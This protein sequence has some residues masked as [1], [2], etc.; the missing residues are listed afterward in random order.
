MRRRTLILVLFI[1]MLAVTVFIS[2]NGGLLLNTEGEQC[3]YFTKVQYPTTTFQGKDTS[4]TFEVYNKNCT[5][6]SFFFMFY[7]SGDPWF[8]EYN[9]TTYKTWRCSQES[10]VSRNYQIASWNTVKPIAHTL[11]VELY[12][13]DGNTSQFQ[14]V[15]MFTISVGVQVKPGNLIV[16]SY[17]TVYLIGLLLLGFYVMILGPVIVPHES[18]M[19]ASSTLRQQLNVTIRMYKP[20][21]GFYIF[22]FASWQIL[23]SSLNAYPFIEPFR[24]SIV[25]IIN[26]S[27]FIL[28]VRLMRIER[29]KF[30]EYGFLWPDE[31]R[32]YVVVSLLLAVLYSFVAIFLPGI[33]TGYEVFVPLPL[34]EIFSVILLGLVASFVGEAIFRGY[35]QK[36]ISHLGGFSTVLVAVSA[37]FVLYKL[38]LLPF[39][40]PDLF[41]E[42]LSLF[43]VG[44][45]L[46]ILFYRTKTL[47][48][49]ILFY[50]MISVLEMI[51]PVTAIATEYGKLVFE[52]AAAVISLLLLIALTTKAEYEP[53]EELLWEE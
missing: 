20:L 49:P 13:Y 39:N 40:P 3:A 2:T 38:P 14:D 15:R 45:F 27:Y 6:D 48:C 17:E 16:S 26:I 22:V 28:L 9:A 51:V 4:L 52:L 42:A 10:S 7:L 34:T 23:N 43:V 32:K 31:T 29:L 8:D 18:S 36:R 37:M 44:V 46:G 21:I 1:L 12:S 33:L 19:N 41:L 25:L 35:I 50:F 53:A 30:K 5:T 47:L 24:Q 11:R